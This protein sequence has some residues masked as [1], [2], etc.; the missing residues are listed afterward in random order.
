MPAANAASGEAGN[1]QADRPSQAG[2]S[3][4][5]DRDDPRVTAAAREAGLTM[6]QRAWVEGQADGPSA[7]LFIVTPFRT[8]QLPWSDS[9]DT[10][11][12]PAPPPAD[13][14]ANTLP[15]RGTNDPARLNEDKP[16][17]PASHTGTAKPNSV[18][19]PSGDS[20]QPQPADPTQ[21]PGPESP[22]NPRHSERPDRSRHSERPEGVEE[23][24]P[25]DRDDFTSIPG[26]GPVTAGK[27]HDAGYFTYTD[28]DTPAIATVVGPALAAKIH[29]W[30]KE[31]KP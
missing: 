14:A 2:P 15:H 30:L 29:A 27:L 20:D 26:V 22:S 18:R 16:A 25:S 31:N 28:L 4:S 8:H 21:R 7:I 10:D 3:A 12:A 11:T 6:I 5:L 17:V 23:S 13:R 9:D 19:P 1:C 24:P